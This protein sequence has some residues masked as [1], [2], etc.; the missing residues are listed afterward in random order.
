MYVEHE[1]NVILFG[2]NDIFGLDL[3]GSQEG[4]GGAS[5][6]SSYGGDS[7]SSDI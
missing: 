4:G 2:D 7:P 1:M 5:G 6:T 3:N